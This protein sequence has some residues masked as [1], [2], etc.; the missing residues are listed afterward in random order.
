[1]SG[2]P[3]KRTT[4]CSESVSFLSVPFVLH[5]THSGQ[6]EPTVNVGC[7]RTAVPAD[8]KNPDKQRGLGAR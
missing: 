5:A 1:M 6:A 7:E 8:L 3:I 2:L 4:V